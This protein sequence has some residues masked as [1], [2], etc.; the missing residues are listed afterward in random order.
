MIYHRTRKGRGIL[1]PG[2]TN[3]MRGWNIGGTGEKNSEGRD[4]PVS[5]VC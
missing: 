2:D 3:K 4:I 1:L 5:R